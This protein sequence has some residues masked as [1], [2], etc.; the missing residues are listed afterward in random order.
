[1]FGDALVGEA[2]GALDSALY[3]INP[4]DPAPAG[5]ALRLLSGFKGLIIHGISA[6]KRGHVATY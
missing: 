4:E 5:P 1:M 2:T 6:C 3:F